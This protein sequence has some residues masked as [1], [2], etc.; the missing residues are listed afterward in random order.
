M[1]SVILLYTFIYFHQTFEAVI[2]F[3]GGVLEQQVLLIDFSSVSL[4]NL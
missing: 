3:V 2:D 4:L 1:D